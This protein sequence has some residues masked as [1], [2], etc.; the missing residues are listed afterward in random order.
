ML[1]RVLHL[2]L[3]WDRKCVTGPKERV[4]LLALFF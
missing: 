1:A 3:L 2:A 4:P